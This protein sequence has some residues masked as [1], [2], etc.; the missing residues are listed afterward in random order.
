MPQTRKDKERALELLIRRR[1]FHGWVFETHTPEEE[2][3]IKAFLH[4]ETD[5]VPCGKQR[6]YEL[7]TTQL[8]KK[9][10]K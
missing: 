10:E 8:R 4:L 2:T 9:K 5:V 3:A 1:T 6:I 7:V